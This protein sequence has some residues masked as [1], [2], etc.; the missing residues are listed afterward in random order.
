MVNKMNKLGA[1]EISFA[2]LFAIL[3]GGF[4]LFLAIFASVK[5]IGVGEQ[6][7]SA[8]TSKEIGILL[9]PL[10]TGFESA[11]SASFTLPSETRIFG[12]C[13][14]EG[15]FGRQLIRVSQKSFNKWVETDLEV[16]FLNKFI[17]NEEFV[18]GNKF[19]VFSK[20]FNF[21]FKVGDLIYLSSANY[22]FVDAPEQIS[23]EIEN[24]NQANL[25][26]EDCSDSSV[27]VCFSS[28]SDCNL[29]VDYTGKSVKKS[30]GTMYFED[31]SLMYAAIFSDKEVYECQIKR[32]MKKIEK[33]SKIYQDKIVITSREGCDSNLG[34]DL[35]ALSLLVNRVESSANLGINLKSLVEGIEDKNKLSSE[36]KLW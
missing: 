2:W 30:S 10:E 31:D 11:R 9:N 34:S 16:Q 6:E 18:E 5:L 7:V 12:S 25:I 14:L 23:R 35:S 28:G 1:F 36:C 13:D 32:L 33:L 3:V 19:Y 22:C 21:P 24:L 15:N 26:V 27:K 29:E 20:P 8:K 4:I 17:F